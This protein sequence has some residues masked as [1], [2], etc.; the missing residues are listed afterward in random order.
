MGEAG[1][2]AVWGGGGEV[3]GVQVGFEAVSLGQ[4]EIAKGA[5]VG[6]GVV[7]GALDGQL[8]EQ[9]SG[10]DFVET[11]ECGFAQDAVELPGAV[12]ALDPFP[13]GWSQAA[14]HDR[15]KGVHAVLEG[16][17]VAEDAAEGG[18]Q[19]W[20]HGGKVSTL[21]QDPERVR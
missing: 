12:E 5:G 16:L 7:E 10:A 14:Q 8:V 18:L 15:S 11:R 17:L 19:T 9:G 2:H 13:D 1:D 20:P 21:E 4:R 6:A 3:E